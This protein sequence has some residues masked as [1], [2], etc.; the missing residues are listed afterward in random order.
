MTLNPPPKDFCPKQG[1]IS[2]WET[3]R[4]RQASGQQ[5]IRA[6]IS[7]VLRWYGYINLDNLYSHQKAHAQVNISWYFWEGRTAKSQ[8]LRSLRLQLL[9]GC[10]TYNKEQVP[11]PQQTRKKLNQNSTNQIQYQILFPFPDKNCRIQ[12]VHYQPPRS[13]RWCCLPA[14]LHPL[15]FNLPQKEQSMM[16]LIYCHA[17]YKRLLTAQGINF[18]SILHIYFK[19]LNWIILSKRNC[20]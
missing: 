5:G 17:G 9:P 3:D 7:Q 11:F 20:T 10:G 4:G 19:I 13:K 8:T 14:L 6:G 18:P 16:H 12:A 2:A 15:L 1:R